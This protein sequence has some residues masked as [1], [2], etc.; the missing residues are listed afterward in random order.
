[1]C[2]DD[3]QSEILYSVAHLPLAAYLVFY[4]MLMHL[5]SKCSAMAKILL[6]ANSITCDC[7]CVP[8]GHCYQAARLSAEAA[9][10]DAKEK[11]RSIK[12]TKAELE[13]DLLKAKVCAGGRLDG[14]DS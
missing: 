2:K 9:A 1:V 8:A 14:S 10:E 7:C 13:E 11:V 4:G 3:C 5:A 6:R 12:A